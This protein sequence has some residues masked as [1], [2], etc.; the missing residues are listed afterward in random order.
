[1]WYL[2]NIKAYL[3]LECELLK[4]GSSLFPQSWESMVNEDLKPYINLAPAG[5]GCHEALDICE[6][7]LESIKSFQVFDN[8]LILGEKLQEELSVGVDQCALMA[9]FPGFFDFLA[10]LDKKRRALI[11]GCRDC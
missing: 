11:D 5:T 2:L 1:M 8:F 7:L 4:Q 3:N 10:Y 6:T 9:E